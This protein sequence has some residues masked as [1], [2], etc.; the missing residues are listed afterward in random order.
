MTSHF[1]V[2]TLTDFLPKARLLDRAVNSFVANCKMAVF[3]NKSPE[4][5]VI[6]GYGLFR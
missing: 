5:C 3:I 1:A 4:R 6:L 2:G